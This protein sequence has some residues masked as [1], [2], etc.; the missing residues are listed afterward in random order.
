MSCKYSIIYYS[1]NILSEERINIGL[2]AYNDQEAQ[3]R[4]LSTIRGWNRVKVFAMTQDISFLLDF[5]ENLEIQI[6]AGKLSAQDIEER[7]Q[8]WG[9]AIMFAEPKGSLLCPSELIE[10]IY[11]DLIFD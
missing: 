4:C 9:N 3:A 1:H 2:V 7:V 5:V 11:S 6:L 10:S 8:N